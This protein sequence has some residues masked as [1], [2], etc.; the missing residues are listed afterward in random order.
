MILNDSAL[1]ITERERSIIALIARYHRKTDPTIDHGAYAD[2]NSND[3]KTVLTLSA[4]LR[5]ADGLDYTH[6]TRISGISCSVTEDQVLCQIEGQGDL[7]V[8][9]ERAI[10]KSNLFEQVF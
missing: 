4:I 5:V 3:K 9:R 8:E 2:L 6:A 7:G 1:Q 10:Q